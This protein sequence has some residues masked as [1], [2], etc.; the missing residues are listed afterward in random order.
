MHYKNFVNATYA[1]AAYLSE[2]APDALAA[3]IEKVTRYVGLDKIYLETYRSGVTVERGKM[4]QIKELCASRGLALAG[5]VTTTAQGSLMGAMCYTDPLTRERL[6]DVAAY[7][8][9]LFDEFILDDFF[10][11]NCRCER[12]AEA[13][14][15][16]SWADFRLMQM[17]DVA[18][19]VIVK[20]AKAANGRVR[21]VIKYPNWYESFPACGYNLRETPALFD[22]VYA[23]TETRDP[24]Y[25]HQ[26]LQRYLSYF[27][28]RLLE[29]AA[30]GRNGGGWYD[31][32]ECGLEDYVQQAY[33]TL[34]AKCRENMLFCLPLLA[35]Y[36][37][38]YA[39]AA[40]AVYDDADGLMGRLGSPAGVAC[41]KPHNS[42]GERH[43]YDYLG[44]LGLPLDPYPYYPENAATVLLTA[45]AAH[46]GR[47]TEHIKGTLARGGD[48]FVTSGLYG[49]LSGKGIEDILPLAVTGGT[50]AAARFTNP[51][52]GR[53]NTSFVSAAEPLALPLMEYDTNNLWALSS[54]LTPYGS[55]PWLLRGACGNGALYV[56]G[57]PPRFA[58][59]YKLPPE[60][61]TLLRGEMRLPVT[62]ECGAGVGLFLYD[63]N[64]FI[65]CSFL[66]EPVNVKMR[67]ARAGTALTQLA[68]TGAARRARSLDGESVYEV[69]LQ[70]GRYHAFEYGESR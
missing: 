1:P 23:G 18:E 59:L 69:T 33:L 36:P 14:G 26:N 67:F 25:T 45:S 48:V 17:R 30:P 4:E 8:A 41:Y 43:L 20:P 55:H 52:Y 16:R 13:K 21:V 54:A 65:V 70:P 60:T 61:L 28:P 19:N 47:I 24:H 56:L 57:I 15:G 39:A 10:F 7:T 44:M 62:L 5:G 6:G 29:R 42:Q 11:T 53:N 38:V 37:A 63:N 32:F 2:S 68:G 31:L 35:R 9:G 49:A 51:G 66:T 50:A 40:G 58:D 46:D 12:C 22:G 3:D 27:L 64:T 34:F